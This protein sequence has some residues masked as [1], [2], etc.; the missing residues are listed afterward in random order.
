M[1][2]GFVDCFNGWMR[3]EPL[4][5]T[6]FFGLRHARE[7]VA[8]WIEDYNTPRI[9]A[10]NGMKHGD[11]VTRPMCRGVGRSEPGARI[12]RIHVHPTGEGSGADGPDA[13]FGTKGY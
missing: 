3:D 2:N 5:E 12:A 6:L 9:S 4:N 8:A 7:A 13:D 11:Q 1:Q 10:S